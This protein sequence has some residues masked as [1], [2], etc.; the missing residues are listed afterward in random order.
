MAEQLHPRQDEIRPPRE[1]FAIGLPDLALVAGLLA[2]F[3]AI[4]FN[5][6]SNMVAAGIRPGFGFL[7]QQAGFDLSETL[8]PYDAGDTYLRAIA[9][10]VA[11]TLV[12][13]AASLMIACLVGLFAGL[14]SVSPSRAARLLALGYV[15][16]FRNLPKILVLLVI[17]VV[18]VNGLPAI[19]QAFQ[20][21]P[22]L[23]SNRAIYLPI[24]V[25]DP[26]NRWWL[27]L[28]ILLTVPA[29]WLWVLYAAGRHART[30]RRGPVLSVSL[31]LAAFIPFAAAYALDAPLGLSWPRL[32][33]FAMRG[34]VSFSTQFCT[35]ALALG[36]YHGAQIAEVIRG[37]IEAIPRGQ[38]E[39]AAAL[40]LSGGQRTRLIVVP[41]VLRAVVP[42]LNN[43]FVNLLKNTSIAIAVGYSDLMSVAGTSINQTF[44][45]LELMVVT[46][47]IYL[48]MC[49]A[50]TGIVNNWSSRLRKREGR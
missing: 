18:A 47:A 8:I 44:R 46:M 39:A 29:I 20:A 17:F 19:R 24:L 9:A 14:V 50:L 2:F 40:G 48:A 10:G 21:G 3:G 4:A 38:I 45:P 7:W 37:G 41:Q 26:L 28:S 43:Q 27:A 30:G 33:G 22:L 35:V 11:N 16:L 34:G 1:G 15:E 31:A 5:V 12:V 13:A 23:I 32:E 49:L 42:P 36:L 25:D 6:Y